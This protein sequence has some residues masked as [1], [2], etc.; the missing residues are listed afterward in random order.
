[1]PAGETNN[2]TFATRLKMITAVLMLSLAAIA[3]LFFLQQES[4]SEST[5]LKNELSDYMAIAHNIQSDIVAAKG[6]VASTS[7]EKNQQQL[8]QLSTLT[9]E[10]QKGTHVFSLPKEYKH[11]ETKAK[12]LV[13]NLAIYHRQLKE[14]TEHQKQLTPASKNNI[15]DNISSSEKKINNY[16]KEQ[17]AVYLFSLFTQIQQRQKEFSLSHSNKD[18]DTLHK[19]AS[20]LRK[21]IPSSPL[22]KEDH[23]ALNTLLNEYLSVFD[24]LVAHSKQTQTLMAEL[25]KTYNQL[26]PI[27]SRDI[28]QIKQASTATI[29]FSNNSGWQREV[30]FVCL[31][32]LSF[33]CSYFLYHTLHKSMVVSGKS[34]MSQL[35]VMAKK[36]N[37]HIDK[38]MTPDT[39]LTHCLKAFESSIEKQ[40]NDMSSLLNSLQQR[41][42]SIID[43]QETA[44]TKNSHTLKS[45]N[46]IS[47]TI[48][49]IS[50]EFST[51]IQTTSSAQSS[52]IHA[53]EK[54]QQGQDKLAQL[55]TEI[56]KLDQQLESSTSKINQLTSNCEAI[57][58]VVD[59]ITHITG[60][61][62]LLALNAAIEAARAGEQ[63]R[64][65]AVVADE[66]RALA[67][68]T[69]AAA[70]DIK[71]QIEEI[72][73]GSRESAQ[74]M[75][76][77]R[78]M[79]SASVDGAKDAFHSLEDATESIHS[80][81]ESNQS[82]ASSAQTQADHAAQVSQE[83]HH[84][85]DQ[86]DKTL[87]KNM[88]DFAQKN[89]L[90]TIIQQ[91]S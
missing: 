21:E 62:N 87:Q 31:I 64:G 69:A 52:A 9:S 17:N 28:E 90:Q 91:Y 40:K 85:H 70:E 19:L 38:S 63:G 10:L 58:T 3:S 24:M 71:I 33:L 32:L 23:Q 56:E 16:L 65:F 50:T 13:F 47:N 77:S 82:I 30:I 20:T 36:Y 12:N 4:S 80:L 76:K 73:K 29:S 15:P 55:T 37:V 83:T 41:E 2:I 88:A 60:Q 8:E 54:S 14:L 42:Q 27:E 39:V 66:V 74:D 26:S 72:Q 1:M 51:I 67:S 49:G 59:M 78:Q 7:Y 11:L 81:Q 86:L 35:L 43:Q 22:I 48:Q 34:A 6:I 61:T 84:L 53:Q 46:D 18:K 68:K 25:N 75:E 45:V 89:N 44:N 57:G 79:V 5:Q